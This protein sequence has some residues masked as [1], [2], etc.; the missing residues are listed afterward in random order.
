MWR[1]EM[2]IGEQQIIYMADCTNRKQLVIE[3]GGI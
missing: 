3:Q 2:I 1:D